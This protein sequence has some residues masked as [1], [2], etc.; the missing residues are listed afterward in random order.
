[1]ADNQI[2][3]TRIHELGLEGNQPTELAFAEVGDWVL[4]QFPLAR[5]GWL[6]GAA[7]PPQVAFG[8]LPA[9]IHPADKLVRIHPAAAFTTPEAAAHWLAGK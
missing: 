6:C 2:P 4:W 9:L 3:E 5:R 1:M 7:H 8:W